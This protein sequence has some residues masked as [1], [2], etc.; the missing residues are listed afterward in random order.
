MMPVCIGVELADK[1][2]ALHPDA[3]IVLMSGYTDHDLAPTAEARYPFIRKPF[4]LIDPHDSRSCRPDG[5]LA[6]SANPV[7][8]G[9]A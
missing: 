5:R 3:P 9:P 6:A 7:L 4:L 8:D 1:I 2:R